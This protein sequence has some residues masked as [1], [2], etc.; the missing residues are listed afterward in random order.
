MI[1]L[2]NS[3][4]SGGSIEIHDL[5]SDGSIDIILGAYAVYDAPLVHESV[6]GEKLIGNQI[7]MIYELHYSFP[8]GRLIFTTKIEVDDIDGDGDNDIIVYFDNRIQTVVESCLIDLFLNDGSRSF[9]VSNIMEK[10]FV[11]KNGR[12]FRL[13]W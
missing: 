7:E 1:L 3:F 12:E 8:L 4:P 2:I 5:D 9:S 6:L 10:P 11:E 13:I